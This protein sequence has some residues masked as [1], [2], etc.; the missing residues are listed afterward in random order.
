M[1]GPEIEVL[2]TFSGILRF[3]GFNLE[4][5]KQGMMNASGNINAE[6]VD[7]LWAAS[8]KA[9][10][11][12]LIESCSLGPSSWIV[13]I[14]CGRGRHVL[15]FL[16]R[17]YHNVVGVDVNGN[18]TLQ[19]KASADKLS[20]NTNLIRGD[21][22]SLPLQPHF[23]FAYTMISAYSSFF[24]SGQQEIKMRARIGEISR[25]LVPNG[26][27]AADFM[28]LSKLKSSY[29]EYAELVEPNVWESV[30]DSDN[31][32][33]TT[34]R[35]LDLNSRI[36]LTTMRWMQDGQNVELETE[37]RIKTLDEQV[38]FLRSVGLKVV[39]TVTPRVQ[40]SDDRSI[41]IATRF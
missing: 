4:K 9:D 2:E 24:V 38:E 6:Q 31:G 15:E 13:D 17:G 1:A 32:N 23:D 28:D 40:L 16:K 14:A 5:L 36:E 12:S 19:A 41:I 34:T 29:E 30:N 8:S 33:K 11:D 35:R 25:I 10:V 18:Q 26:K 3:K 27:F 37:R 21:Y 39:G 20:L 7:L 22:Y